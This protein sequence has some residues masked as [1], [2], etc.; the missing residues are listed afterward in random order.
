MK[1]LVVAPHYNTFIKGWA[2]ALASHVDS[3]MVLVHHNRFADLLKILPFGGY[4]NY[5][6][7][8]TSDRLLNLEGKPEN[9]SVRLISKFY[10]PQSYRNAKV[11]DIFFKEMLSLLE[12][13][14]LGDEYIVHAH[15]TW[16][17]GYIGARLKESLGARLVVTG[18]GYDVYDLPFRNDS[19]G[20]RIRY[21]LSKAD[22][23]TTVSE[24]NRRIL[25]EK[26][27]LIGQKVHL[28]PNG[29]SRMFYPMD[30]KDARSKLNIPDGEKVVLSVGSL[31]EVKGHEYLI[32][33][34]ANLSRSLNFQAFIVGQGHLKGKLTRLV[35]ETG[36][37]ERVH[38][39]GPRPHKEIP[40]WMNAADILALPS[41]MEGLPTVVLE[42]LACGTPVVGTRVGGVP[43]V[44]N[45]ESGILVE[46][47]D[48]EA[49][50]QAVKE[51]LDREWDRKEIA[52]RGSEFYWDKI[53]IRY[54]K[55]YSSLE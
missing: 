18:H 33:A 49:L 53:A 9:V 25:V 41:L 21:A 34:L 31:K 3:I 55:L 37:E 36:L 1:V 47:G 7:R 10:Y 28:I 50:S 4:L 19:L 29:V 12:K 39:V 23:V 46:P 38:L 8:F 51:A 45:E 16:P 20:E 15:F 13:G 42:A 11:G 40:L 30:R 17:P 24:P 27:G 44:V 43:D 26:L 52:R 6:R 2:E 22:A 14:S 54:E 35:K 32:R 48:E 5:V